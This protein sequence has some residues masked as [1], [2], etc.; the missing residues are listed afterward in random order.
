MGNKNAK[1]TVTVDNINQKFVKDEY[2][3]NSL[4]DFKRHFG[5]FA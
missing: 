5:L 1:D 3:N 2:S 4:I